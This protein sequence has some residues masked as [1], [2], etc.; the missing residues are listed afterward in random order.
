MRSVITLLAVVAIALVSY[1]LFFLQMRKDAGGTANPVQVIDVVGVKNDLL[2]IAQAERAYQAE[3][4]SYASLG[5]LT[6]TGSLTF[7][8]T[9]RDGYTYAIETTA[10]TFRV[11]A[12]CP[13]SAAAGCSDYSVDQSMEIT[14]AH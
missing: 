5:D 14:P 9:N 1:K 8:R 3:H 2:A 6:S 4:G 12:H 10:D 7:R 13:A 11:V